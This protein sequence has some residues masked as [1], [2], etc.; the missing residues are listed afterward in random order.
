MARERAAR[1]KERAAERER[2]CTTTAR[3]PSARRYAPLTQLLAPAASSPT[4]WHANIAQALAG[5]PV[6]LP[7]V[8][9]VPMPSTVALPAPFPLGSAPVPAAV[10]VPLAGMAPAAAVLPPVALHGVDAAQHAHF[11]AHP[12]ALHAHVAGGP[13]LAP[14]HVAPPPGLMVHQVDVAPQPES[15][16]GGSVGMYEHFGASRVRWWLRPHFAR[17]VVCW[18]SAH[19]FVQSVLVIGAGAGCDSPLVVSGG[20]SGFARIHKVN[21]PLEQPSI[22]LAG[23][24]GAVMC[25]DAPR[26]PSRGGANAPCLPTG[27]LF[28]GS[29][30]HTAVRWDLAAG[31]IATAKLIGHARSVHCLTLGEGSALGSNVLFTGSRDHTIKMWDLR[32]HRAE[33]TLHGHTGSVTCIGT[34]GWRLLSGGG[35]NRGADDDEVLSVD[36]SLK[37]WDLRRIADGPPPMREGHAKPQSSAALVWSREAPSP[38]EPDQPTNVPPGDPVLSL[39]LLERKVLT[40]HGGKQWTARIWDL[41]HPDDDTSEGDA[42]HGGARDFGVAAII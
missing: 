20:D 12:L 14:A 6:A 36:S 22:S 15:L 25:L 7:T 40:S 13:L 16:Q 11:A 30:D 37:L 2:E 10:A 3:A 35:Y 17:K 24:T 4:A 38:L 23:H 8:P 32:T 33:H 31:G 21:A 27:T 42:A 34:H 1:E 26:G 29:V 9:A 5:A 41:D 39:Q 18:H 28:S 19:D